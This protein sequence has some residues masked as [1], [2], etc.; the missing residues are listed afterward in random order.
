MIS[1]KKF[2][3]VFRICAFLFATIGILRQTGILF[4]I[5]SIRPFMY[6]TV[7][8]NIL[9]VILF[10]ML[11]IKTINSIRTGINESVGYYPRI[12]MICTVYLLV[13]LI[14]FWALL[15]PQLRLDMDYLLSFEN[16]AVHLITPLLCLIDYVL[17]SEARKLKYSD[18]Y[19]VCLYPV[20]YVIFSIGAGLSG[21]VYGYE[22]VSDSPF[23]S[24]LE[25]VP[26]RVPYFFLDYYRLGF[27]VIVYCV[28]I[29]LFFL[30]LSHIIYWIDHKVRK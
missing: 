21:Y 7:Q 28:G 5:V 16:L 14:V 23:S 25:L 17:F 15:V 11:I 26:V 30:L 3:L 1:N 13:T 20:L 29:L 19:Y 2:A 10:A 18:V 6:Y 12:S 8:S 27:M 4:G 22:R 9:A 24:H